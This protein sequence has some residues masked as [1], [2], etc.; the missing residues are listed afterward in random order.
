MRFYV[1]IGKGAFF[2][3]RKNGKKFEPEY[4]DGNPYYRYILH[5]I[6]PSA[7]QMVEALIENNNLN[8]ESEIELVLIENSDR[9]RNVNVK[10]ALNSCVKQVIKLDEILL[11]LTH[12]LLKNKK[13]YIDEFGINYDEECYKIRSNELERS[14]YS[15]LA[16]TVD[17]DMLMN[18]V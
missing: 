16:Y 17:Q 12:D 15:L 1:V 11:R 13:L 18:Y 2:L 9:V 5:K 6:K 14:N 10:Q 4:I 3:Y 7:K 8:N